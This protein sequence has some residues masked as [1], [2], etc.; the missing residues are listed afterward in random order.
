MAQALAAMG[1]AL[2]HGVASAC[3]T[4]ERFSA[5]EKMERESW[6]L[7]LLTDCQSK[8]AKMLCHFLFVT[9]SNLHVSHLRKKN[10][11]QTNLHVSPIGPFF[12][13]LYTNISS[14]LHI[15]FPLHLSRYSLSLA[16]KQTPPSDL[17]PTRNRASHFHNKRASR[18]KR[19]IITGCNSRYHVKPSSAPSR[20]SHL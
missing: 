13:I 14:Y 20:E 16:P 15:H 7:T 11:W 2:H 3:V 18:A 8:S 4:N 17:S 1:V 10:Q 12:F 6:Q 19:P 5:S 9:I